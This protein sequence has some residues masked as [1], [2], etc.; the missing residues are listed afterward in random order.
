M[1]GKSHRPRRFIG[2][3][4]DAF[5]TIDEAKLIVGGSNDSRVAAEAEQITKNAAEADK[6]ADEASL[7][8]LGGLYGEYRNNQPLVAAT[9]GKMALEIIDNRGQPLCTPGLLDGF[10]DP[11]M[12]HDPLSMSPAERIAN[13]LSSLDL[14]A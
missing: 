8:I 7:I 3:F 12:R 14:E 13:A 10:S 5:K 2:S 11:T 4:S 9:A 6:I 1:F